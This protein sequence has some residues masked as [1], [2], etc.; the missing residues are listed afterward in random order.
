MIK[1]TRVLPGELED[2][3]EPESYGFDVIHV[4]PPSE[5]EAA[6]RKADLYAQ[7][8]RRT[9]I[10]IPQLERYLVRGARDRRERPHGT[11]RSSGNEGH[12]SQ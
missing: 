11:P 7:A 6:A 10:V 12:E 3:I 5:A 9:G 1:L 4:E 2:D 8:K